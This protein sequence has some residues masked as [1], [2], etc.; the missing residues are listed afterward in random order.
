MSFGTL[1]HKMEQLN[2][3]DTQI[4]DF[5]NNIFLNQLKNNDNNNNDDN[6][7]DYSNIYILFKSVHR[8]LLETNLQTNLYRDD[9]Q[10]CE[11][12]KFESK[13]C[14]DGLASNVSDHLLFVNYTE[15]MPQ[16][17]ILA[18]DKVKLMIC[19][20]GV[21]HI[22]EA[23]YH[24]IPTITIPF[25]FDQPLQSEKGV[26]IGVSYQLDVHAFTSI[27][28]NNAIAYMFENYQSYYNKVNAWSNAMKTYPGSSIIKFTIDAV[29]NNISQ[30]FQLQNRQASIKYDQVNDQIIRFDNQD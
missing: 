30:S 8:E 29:L 4:F 13:E 5:L 25:Q 15:W 26:H 11:S 6:I 19:H 22:Q 17:A 27:L 9:E 28:L 3:R 1:W 2:H 24:S 12:Q 23:I 20:A 7:V 21:G 10:S 18:H 16:A 14:K